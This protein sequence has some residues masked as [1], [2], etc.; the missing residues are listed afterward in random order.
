[1]RIEWSGPVQNRFAF[2]CSQTICDFIYQRLTNAGMTALFPVIK[3]M[4]L[5]C[6]ICGPWSC[7][8]LRG[9]TEDKFREGGKWS[10]I[11]PLRWSAAQQNW[12]S[13]ACLQFVTNYRCNCR[14]WLWFYASSYSLLNPCCAQS[15]INIEL[16]V[17]IK[18]RLPRSMFKVRADTWEKEFRQSR[19]FCPLGLQEAV[20]QLRTRLFVDI[21]RIAS[22][23][24]PLKCDHRLW[25]E[26]G[27]G[28]TSGP[29]ICC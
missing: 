18:R 19:L 7:M 21:T 2:I 6:G 25:T 11:G 17:K 28:S 27:S 3:V 23:V 16:L 9:N 22:V 8:R 24:D 12:S 13:N 1:M 29:C 14:T 10:S 4:A 15:G 26:V 20:K 5:L